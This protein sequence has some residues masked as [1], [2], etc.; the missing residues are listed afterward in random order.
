MTSSSD[1]VRGRS[2][3]GRLPPDVAALNRLI[4]KRFQEL[5]EAIHLP[6]PTRL[7]SGER[8][9]GQQAILGEALGLSAAEVARFE[10]ARDGLP[11]AVLLRL[12]HRYALTPDYFLA[13]EAPLPAIFVFEQQQREFENL[14]GNLRAFT[15][16]TGPAR[17]HLRQRGGQVPGRKGGWLKGLPRNPR[18]P[19]QLALRHLWEQARASGFVPATIEELGQWGLEHGMPLP[20]P[21]SAPPVASRAN[22]GRS[23]RQSRTRKTRASGRKGGWLKGLPR[24]PTTPE[25]F[26]LRQIWQEGRKRGLH[27]ASLAGLKQWWANSGLADSLPPP[28]TGA[29]EADSTERRAPSGRGGRVRRPLVKRRRST[30]TVRPEP[31]DPDEVGPQQNVEEPAD[32]SPS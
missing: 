1:T 4:Q 7:K 10:A 24:K 6:E 18:T 31:A 17:G 30:P 19:H 12:M 32:E 11:A 13:P 21:D 2:S 8:R 3:V 25:D 28:E 20:A 14:L 26:H 23:R 5:R 27:F 22:S 9:S 16:V 15:P 29:E